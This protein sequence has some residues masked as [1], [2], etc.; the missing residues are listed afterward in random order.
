MTFVRVLI[1]EE[2]HYFHTS[3]IQGDSGEVS[4]LILF[5]STFDAKPN[6]ICHSYAAV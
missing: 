4:T 5:D 1:G 3:I 2:I 6:L